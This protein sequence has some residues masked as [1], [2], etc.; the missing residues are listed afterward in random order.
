MLELRNIVKEINEEIFKYANP[1]KIKDFA[2]AQTGVK[3][4]DLKV[5]QIGSYAFSDCKRLENIRI[6]GHDNR[7]NE[8]SANAFNGCNNLKTAYFGEKIHY[9]ALD[10]FILNNLSL[11]QIDEN[12]NKINENNMSKI[13]LKEE[14]LILI[15]DASGNILSEK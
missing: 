12:N 2:F 15:K 13:V 10:F 14:E 5:S 6:E 9:I 7:Y 1:Y 8:I 3:E 11:V 4:L